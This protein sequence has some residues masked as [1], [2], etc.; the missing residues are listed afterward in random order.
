MKTPPQLLEYQ[1]IEYFDIAAIRFAGVFYHTPL[2]V[3]KNLT[4][5]KTCPVAFFL[6]K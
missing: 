2:P 5:L 6:S 3:G 1:N 4:K